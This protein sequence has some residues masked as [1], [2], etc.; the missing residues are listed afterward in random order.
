MFNP[1]DVVGANPGL[2]VEHV[3]MPARVPGATDGRSVI[4]LDETLSIR[5]GRCVLTHELVH[6]KHGHGECQPRP[7]ERVVRFEAARL[8][9]T[10][11][12]LL[13][14]VPSAESVDHLAE[15]LDVTRLVLDDRVSGLSDDQFRVLRLH[16]AAAWSCVGR[17]A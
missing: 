7:V 11:K 5:E 15:E 13:E 17:Q 1:W 10:W 6:L 9:V 8:L 3:R 2:S 12:R 16:D 14:V 4:W